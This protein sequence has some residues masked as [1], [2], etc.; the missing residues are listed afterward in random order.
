MNRIIFASIESTV[1]SFCEC[2]WWLACLHE[3]RNQNHKIDVLIAVARVNHVNNDHSHLYWMTANFS[4]TNE[5]S[6]GRH[7]LVFEDL[8]YILA[9]FCDFLLDH[10]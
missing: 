5:S 2:V 4:M 9:V 1:L 8:H 7:T 10:G 3:P 6:L